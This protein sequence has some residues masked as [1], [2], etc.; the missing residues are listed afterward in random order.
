M[1]ELGG[2]IFSTMVDEGLS[3]HVTLEQNVESSEG[4]NSLAPWGKNIPG[5]GNC[6]CKELR[7]ACADHGK[8][9]QKD[10]RALVQEDGRR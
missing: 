8:E 5:G 2:H 7:Q 3:N 9:Q 10:Q 1:P 6:K 4:A